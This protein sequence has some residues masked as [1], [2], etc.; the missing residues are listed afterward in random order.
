[1]Q[2]EKV[3][4]GIIVQ[5][6]GSLRPH[7]PVTVTIHRRL[8][9]ELGETKYFWH[10]FTR[11]REIFNSL[12]NRSQVDADLNDETSV[13]C[14]KIKNAETRPYPTFPP[15]NSPDTSAHITLAL[16]MSASGSIEHVSIVDHIE[17][18]FKKRLLGAVDHWWFLPKVVDGQRVAANLTVIVDLFPGNTW[19]NEL[20]QPLP[21]GS[22][23]AR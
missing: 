13:A 14:A 7:S 2:S 22:A 19:S 3:G 5:E 20:V 21:T 6:I 23:P 15:E 16:K 9:A 1:M 10:V 17:A 8:S 11:D 18:K 12:M 4:G